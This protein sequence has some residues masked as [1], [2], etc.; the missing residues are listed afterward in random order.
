MLKERKEF[1]PLKENAQQ[2]AKLKSD[3]ELKEMQNVTRKSRIASTSVSQTV[4]KS[5]LKESQQ[6]LR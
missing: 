2:E 3:R 1:S 5:H 4:E 6:L